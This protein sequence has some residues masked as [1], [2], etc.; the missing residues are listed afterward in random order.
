MIDATETVDPFTP[1]ASFKAPD[2]NVEVVL[3]SYSWSNSAS[4]AH[5]DPSIRLIGVG[6]S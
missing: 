1:T 5:R 6:F 2:L 3:F 4:A